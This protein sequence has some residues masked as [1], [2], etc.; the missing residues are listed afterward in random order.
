MPDTQLEDDAPPV[1]SNRFFGWMRELDVQR[2]PG[3]IGGAA[4]GLAA[5]LGIDPLIV[6]GILV[7]IAILGGPVLFLYAAAWALLPNEKGVIHLEELFRGRFTSAIAGIGALVILSLLPI[8]AIATY[9]GNYNWVPFP[10]LRPL[11]G[12]L[13]VLLLIGLAVWFVVWIARRAAREPKAAAQ[14]TDVPA[15]SEPVAPEDPDDFTAWREQQEAVKAETEEFRLAAAA[16][17]AETA[18]ER[19]R[20]QRALWE[21]GVAERA[22][23][24]QARRLANPRLAASWVFVILGAGLVAS[25][26][27]ALVASVTP[28]FT[29]TVLFAGLASALLVTGIAIIVAGAVRRRSGFLSFLAAVLLFF[30]VPLA[31]LPGDRDLVTTEYGV[32]TGKYAQL[33]GNVY[34]YVTPEMTG[35]VDIWQGL[36]NL[37]ITMAEG[38]SAH[39]DVEVVSGYVGGLQTFN[40]DQVRY[41]HMNPIRHEGNLDM[42]SAQLGSTDQDLTIR[43]WQGSGSTYVTYDVSSEAPTYVNPSAPTAEPTPSPEPTSTGDDK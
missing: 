22:A 40:T 42:Y 23:R 41:A 15:P 3:W 14:P 10:D 30:M 19:S 12:V 35:T 27:G 1:H 7:V 34:L 43:L 21:A 24:R 31:F 33:A 20:E 18:A 9:G 2:R 26:I 17:A 6:R 39:L 25:A 37:H 28:S 36:G 16:T 5:R 4:T 38:A 11:F 32:T 29:G 13:W 8:G